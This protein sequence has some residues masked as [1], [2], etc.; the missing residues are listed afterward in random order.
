[1][2]IVH[3]L[4]IPWFILSDAEPKVI[5]SIGNQL[6][7]TVYEGA[8]VDIG[9]I[10]QVVTCRPGNDFEKDLI[11]DG[12]TEEMISAIDTFEAAGVPDQMALGQSY[13]DNW[14]KRN[15]NNNK[16]RHNTNRVCETC[17]QNIYEEEK[18]DFSGEDGRRT[19]LEEFLNKGKNKVRYASVI[20][21]RIVAIADKERTLPTCVKRLFEQLDT[22]LRIAEDEANG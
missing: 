11:D 22:V 19:A 21:D 3:K 14:M 16:G 20:A 4:D 13:F 6:S 12:Y 5:K 18:Y 10:S 1:M 8:H 9:Q 7:R 15:Q 17:H 2:R